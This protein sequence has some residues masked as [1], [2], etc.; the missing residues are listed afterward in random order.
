[1]ASNYQRTGMPAVV[2]ASE[3]RHALLQ[4]RQTV[5]EVLSRDKIPQ[6]L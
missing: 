5:D 1:M 6:W 3:G 4:A 2:L